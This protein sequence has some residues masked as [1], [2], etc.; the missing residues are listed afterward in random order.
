MYTDRVQRCAGLLAGNAVLSWMCR[1]RNKRACVLVK[2][3]RRGVW[4]AVGL[5]SYGAGNVM[6]SECDRWMMANSCKSEWY[7]FAKRFAEPIFFSIFAMLLTD[8][9]CFQMQRWGVWHTV[10]SWIHD[11]FMYR[12]YKLT[13]LH[14]Q[15]LYEKECYF[16]SC[17]GGKTKRIKCQTTTKTA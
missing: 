7:L 4:S 14:K 10:M 9:I 5:R 12:K 6:S 16:V 13:A 1:G 8:A 17:I 2:S 11:G 15:W 3:W